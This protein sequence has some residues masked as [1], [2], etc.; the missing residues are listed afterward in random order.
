M[1]DAP[2]DPVLDRL[3]AVAN[4][5]STLAHE[6]GNLALVCG[7]PAAPLVSLAASLARSCHEAIGLATDTL[8]T[9]ES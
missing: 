9:K 6:L 5:A 3:Q 4:A 1:S 8:Q 2:P 7:G